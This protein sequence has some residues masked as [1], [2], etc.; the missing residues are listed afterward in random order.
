MGLYQGMTIINRMLSDKRISSR[1]FQLEEL[2]SNKEYFS[3]F[4]KQ[5]YK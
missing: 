5:D 3:N 2:V 4:Y 1:N